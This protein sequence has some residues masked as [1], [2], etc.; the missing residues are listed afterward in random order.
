MTLRIFAMQPAG[1]EGTALAAVG[2]MIKSVVASVLGLAFGLLTVSLTASASADEMDGLVTVG[3]RKPGA[4]G[5]DGLP[6]M[7]PM[8]KVDLDD[9]ALTEVERV[10]VQYGGPRIFSGVPLEALIDSVKAPAHADLA[11]LHFGNGVVVPLPYRD[12]TAM[13]RLQPWVARGMHL[14]DKG[15]TVGEFQPITNEL[16]RYYVVPV[17]KFAGNKLVVAER[18]HPDVPAR[19]EKDLSPWM[20]VDSLVAIELVNAAAYRSMLDLGPKAA[21]GLTLF[22]QSCQFC[23]GI[24]QLGAKFGPDFVEP[25]P[26]HKWGKPAM[27]FYWHIKYRRQDPVMR[28]EMMPTLGY[29]TEL[30]A[31]AVWAWLQAAAEHPLR[32]YQP[33]R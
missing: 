31:L 25:V 8:R 33:S 24:R 7:S 19:A 4:G 2:C 1:R 21:T 27:R 11:L 22:R 29:V 23:H 18:W 26:V 16:G 6:E 10:D 5:G 15:M 17:I 9:M 13:R 3:V 20:H 14:V 32:P 12:R 28:G 30:D